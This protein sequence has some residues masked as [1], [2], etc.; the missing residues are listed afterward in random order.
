MKMGVVA[1]INHALDQ[2]TAELII[3]EFGHKVKRVA[4]SDVEDAIKDIRKDTEKDMKSRPP[5]VTIMGHVDHGKTSLLDTIRQ[6]R[7]AE[8]E[9]GGITQHIGA[10]Q[11]NEIKTKKIIT[12]IDTPGHEAFSEMRARGAKF[13]DIVV[14]SLIHI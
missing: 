11:V 6:S 12:F 3:A 5:V 9:S 14:L 1:T 2:D 7:V 13:T 10:Y 8:K 4:E